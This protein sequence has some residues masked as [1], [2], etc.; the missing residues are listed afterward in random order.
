MT[1]VEKSDD[2]NSAMP[3]YRRVNASVLAVCALIVAV[4]GVVVSGDDARNALDNWFGHAASDRA[5]R[6]DMQVLEKW[7]SAL[8][9]LEVDQTFKRVV[10]TTKHEAACK[11]RD[12]QFGFELKECEIDESVANARCVYGGSLLSAI[13]TIA[14]EFIRCDRALREPY[15]SRLA[16]FDSMHVVANRV[17]TPARFVRIE[18]GVGP[19]DSLSERELSALNACPKQASRYF[20]AATRSAVGYR[21]VRFTL[22]YTADAQLRFTIFRRVQ[23]NLDKDSLPPSIAPF[24][25]PEIDTMIGG[26]RRLH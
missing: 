8:T 26:S 12:R 17:F 3:W 10:G 20:C 16:R 6:R 4:L 15:P 22:E 5:I 11:R 1:R 7:L 13:P 25:Y 23:T 9:E 18:S 2:S 14:E 24:R 19:A 21:H